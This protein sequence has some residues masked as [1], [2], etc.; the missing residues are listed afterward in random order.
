[1][2]S[3]PLPG[4]RRLSVGDSRAKWDTPRELKERKTDI[5]SQFLSLSRVNGDA[6]DWLATISFFEHKYQVFS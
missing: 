5:K 2:A 6:V 1:M 3:F 4:Y